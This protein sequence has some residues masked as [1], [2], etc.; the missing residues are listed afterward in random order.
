MGKFQL[1]TSWVQKFLVFF[2]ARWMHQ[3][4]VGLSNIKELQKYNSL[5]GNNIFPNSMLSVVMLLDVFFFSLFKF[6]FFSFM[7]F[8]TRFFECCLVPFSDDEP[9]SLPPRQTLFFEVFSFFWI[10]IFFIFSRAL[11]A[12]VFLS[13]R[14]SND[15]YEYSLQW[16]IFSHA[17]CL[18]L[19][20]QN[21]IFVRDYLDIYS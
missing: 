12:C 2:I 15:L 16:C 17:E 14:R 7:N 1:F 9:E 11:E 3:V 10:T 18:N 13:V 6:S 21:R 20:F 5:D 19:K 8:W 4:R